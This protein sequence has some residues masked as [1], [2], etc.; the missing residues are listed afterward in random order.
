MGV[1]RAVVAG[2]E[3]TRAR[4]REVTSG[5]GA[6]FSRDGGRRDVAHEVRSFLDEAEADLV[7]RGVDPAE[8]RRM[9]RMRYGAE[10]AARD[11]IV[12][13]GW[14]RR[15]ETFLRDTA[16]A[17]RGVRRRPG[18]S[19][20]V[21][22]TLALGIGSSTALFSVIA[23]SLF[24]PL[25]FPEPDRI[26]AILDRAPS[27]DEIPMTFGTHTELQER[28][29]GLSHLAVSR[30]WQPVLGGS[31]EPERLDGRRVS[32]AYF[33]VLGVRPA[34]GPGFSPEADRPGG[35]N[36]VVISHALWVR[37][38]GA[39]PAVI[40]R[41]IP[42]DAQPYSIVGVLSEGLE[43]VSPTESAVWGL[44]QYA[45]PPPTF[46]GREWGHHL[47]MIARLGEGV[48][49]N[50][51][52]AEL[53][54]ISR[55][56]I[57]RFPRPAWAAL[58]AGVVVR[59]LHEEMTGGS[60]PIMLALGAAAFLL[61]VIA[62][63]NLTILLLAR[64]ESRKGELAMRA[65]LGAS[66][67]RLVRQLL[68]E[69][70]VLA[71]IG[72]A[73]GVALAWLG[74]E[75]LVEL[76]PAGLPRLS[77]VGLDGGSLAFALALSALI[78]I[79]AGLLPAALRRGDPEEGGPRTRISSGG[80]R[81]GLVGAEV[82]L[83]AVLLI[84]AGL[85]M[86]T[87][88]RLLDT[89]TGFDATGAIALQVQTAGLDGPD[90]SAPFFDQVLEALRATPGVASAA[91]TNLLPLSGDD[92]SFGVNLEGAPPENAFVGVAQRYVVS[93][94]YFETMG[95]PVLAGRGLLESDRAGTEAVVVVSE[96]M[97]RAFPNGDALGRRV[98][99]GLTDRP[100]F[101]VVGIVGDVRHASLEDG[102]APAV[103]LAPEQW[104]FADDPRWF[105]ARSR[106]ASTAIASAVRGAIASVDP[107]QPIVR[108]HSLTSVVESSEARRRFVMLVLQTF[109]LLALTMSG[110]GLYGVMSGSV[111]ERLPEIGIRT[112]L[113]ASRGRIL[114]L[115]FRRGMAVAAIGTLVG[116]LAASAGTRILGSLLHDVSR[117]DAFTYV[118]VAA[119]LLLVCALACWV[120]AVRAL[121]VEPLETLRQE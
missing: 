26:V 88:G 87:V 37:R 67:G 47:D 16:L 10:V 111:V 28:S 97:A 13:A 107:G 92:S 106:T 99:V 70:L 80:M 85:L 103:Y 77:R 117:F 84:G 119:T 9:V 7:A 5:V 89:P 24:E 48:T 51:A 38:L 113:G 98:H 100:A 82:A 93:P 81:R 121:G 43:S 49:V 1:W 116:L 115:V 75:V 6:L 114:G 44:L 58:E 73:A 91:F 15:V 76:S 63:T 69:G 19:A 86:R 55:D 31:T 64:A 65:L 20:V 61:L 8:A 12:E 57:D 83:A 95:I 39:D 17:L 72:G 21:L 45:P 101:T 68:A 90:G 53:T 23:P 50:A 42:L 62:L 11:R 41:T 40:G 33:D 54:A 4:L 36:E 22:L 35:A 105:V 30:S 96:T 52:R 32:A 29:R 56:P 79:A 112:A 109:A 94:D 60:R 118:G 18:F 66:R 78:G 27:G 108:T 74:V 102:G 25:D 110:L 59:P 71:A 120:P 3:T 2:V 34:I 104:F 14:E 46:E